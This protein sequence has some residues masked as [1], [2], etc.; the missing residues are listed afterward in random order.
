MDVSTP[1]TLISMGTVTF[2]TEIDFKEGSVFFY[3]K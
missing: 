3:Q 2:Y 1:G